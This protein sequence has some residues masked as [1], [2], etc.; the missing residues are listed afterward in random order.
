[1]ADILSDDNTVPDDWAPKVAYQYF[2]EALDKIGRVTKIT[3]PW[4]KALLEDA[5][6]VD[7]GVS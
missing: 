3:A 5:G 4:L 6:F 1:M 7:V 2:N